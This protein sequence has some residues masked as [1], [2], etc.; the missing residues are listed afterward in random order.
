MDMMWNA[1]TRSRAVQIWFAAVIVAIAG[2]FAMGASV[3]G[4]TALALLVLCFA[5]PAILLLMWPGV[6]PITASEVIHGG[7]RRD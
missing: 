7:N 5:P 2:S 4:S 6:Q 3:N 1:M